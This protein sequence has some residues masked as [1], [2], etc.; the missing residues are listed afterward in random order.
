MW[1]YTDTEESGDPEIKYADAFSPV[2]FQQYHLNTNE[3]DLYLGG[4]E[5]EQLF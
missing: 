4:K 2:R 3:K 1:Y 5:P